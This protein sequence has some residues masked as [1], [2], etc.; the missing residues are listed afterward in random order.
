MALSQPEEGSIVL[1]QDASERQLAETSEPKEEEVMK[2]HKIIYYRRSRGGGRFY[3]WTRKVQKLSTP[4]KRMWKSEKAEEAVESKSTEKVIIGEPLM[5]EPML[6][7]NPMDY[8]SNVSNLSDA[9][10][11]P[12]NNDRMAG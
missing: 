12:V 6:I 8:V 9:N 3:N 2:T 10:A 4:L 7:L 1:T 11:Y 5:A